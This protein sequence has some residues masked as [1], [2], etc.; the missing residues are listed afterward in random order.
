[1][2]TQ[3]STFL[4]R[5]HL[6]M[7]IFLTEDHKHDLAID[8]ESRETL[9]LLINW[10]GIKTARPGRPGM[11]KTCQRLFLDSFLNMERSP[12]YGKHQ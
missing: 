7:A 11:S 4:P 2:R 5:I 12:W 8:D 9:T 1:M 10:P 6:F 3:P